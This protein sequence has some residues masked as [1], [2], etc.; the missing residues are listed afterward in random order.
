MEGVR[1]NRSGTT[2]W[3]TLDNPPGNGLYP[4]LLESLSEALKDAD[5]DPAVNSVVIT[6]AGEKFCAGVDGER[7]REGDPTNFATKL[8]GLFKLIPTLGVPLIA[9]VNGD[10]LMS[11]FSL[12]C[13]ADIAIAVEGAK[14]GTLEASLGLWPTIAQVPV[15]HRL[16]PTHALANILTGV[17]FDAKRAYDIGAVAAVTSAE[18]L[19]AEVQRW[20]DLSTRSEVLARGRRSAHKLL[21]LPYLDALD[22]SYEEFTALFSKRQ[23]N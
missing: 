6:G 19:E 22:A 15:L 16:L 7:L 11:G 14:L 5:A 8:V 13:A 3:I 23:P 20:I 21:S 17:P 9:A 12:V 1:T 2:S 18:H 4:G 10:A